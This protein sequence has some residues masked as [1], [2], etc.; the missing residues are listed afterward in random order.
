VVGAVLTVRLFQGRLAE[1]LPALRDLAPATG[2]PITAVVAALLLRTGLRAEAE[3]ALATLPP[4]D[5]APDDW[6][7]MVNWAAACEVAAGA[8]DA[9]LGAA[10]YARLAPYAGRMCV[11]GS[12]AP[13]GPAH[14]FLAL[15]A[16][17][18]GEIATATRHAD[19]ALEQCAAW[20]IPPVAQWLHD[21]RD[22]H[23]F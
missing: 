19:A 15:A 17:A 8:G 16:A 1:A 11:G 2:L 5:L 10:A 12:G 20:Q 18:T 9:E 14:A 21:Q 4:V 22:R 7:A 13:L 3:Q 23:G 6:F